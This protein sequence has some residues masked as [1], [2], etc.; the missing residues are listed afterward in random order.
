[1]STIE[2]NAYQ[3]VMQK[4]AKRLGISIEEAEQSPISES[5]YL[6]AAEA[7]AAR[8]GVDP[9]S[10]Y[11]QDRQRLENSTYPTPECITPD[12]VEDL[13]EALDAH[14]LGIDQLNSAQGEQIVNSIWSNQMKHLETC[15]PCQTLLNACRPT[16]E[17]RAAFSKYVQKKF[18]LV[19][20]EG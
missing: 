20:A 5:R 4:R 6:A 11:E 19:A 1:M 2:S 12:D 16:S 13:F 7:A 18:P 3:R 15:D 14:H 9:K 8:L 10:I 17:G